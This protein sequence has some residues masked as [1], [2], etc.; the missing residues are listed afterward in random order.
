MKTKIDRIEIDPEKLNGKPNIRGIRISVATVL[1]HLAGG[2]SKEA[3]LE[4]Y[5]DLESEDIDAC[6]AYA[7]YLMER[8]GIVQTV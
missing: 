1:G 7:L 8:I 2:D 5:P 3:I 6:V 4:A